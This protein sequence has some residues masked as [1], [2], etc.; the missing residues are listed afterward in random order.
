MTRVGK[1]QDN[2]LAWIVLTFI[3]SFVA[4][5]A[6][7]KSVA[8]QPP[9]DCVCTPCPDNCE[10]AKIERLVGEVKFECADVA[11]Q[12][13]LL[14]IQQEAIEPTECPDCICGPDPLVGALQ[15]DLGSC[16]DELQQLVYPAKW[17]ETFGL[18][19]GYGESVNGDDSKLAHVGFIVTPAKWITVGASYYR[20]WDEEQ[21]CYECQVKA[22]ETDGVMVNAYIHP[23]AKSK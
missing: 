16:K 6:V 4:G 11:E 12:V 23:W 1:K 20:R 19:G 15:Q 17:Y 18:G 3:V 7:G 9:P 21:V 8:G 22:D 2:F 13:S 14:R 10:T 5:G